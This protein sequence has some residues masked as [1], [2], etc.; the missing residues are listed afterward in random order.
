MPSFDEPLHDRRALASC[1]A[2]RA[3]PL[4]AQSDFLLVN[5]HPVFQPRFRTAT[6]PTAAQFVVNVADQLA[7]LYCGPILIK[8]TGVPT[9]PAS[10]G[11]SEA[12]QASFIRSCARACGP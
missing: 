7:Q 3:L 4:A 10:A 11:Y 6:D 5:V 8:E 2:T 12:R 9:A 1:L